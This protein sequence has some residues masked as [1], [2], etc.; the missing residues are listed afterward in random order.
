MSE[1]AVRAVALTY[2]LVFKEVE[3]LRA[4]AQPVIASFLALALCLLT[5][6]G[7]VLAVES[8]GAINV[9]VY[10]Q[11]ISRDD[12]ASLTRAV[13]L[14]RPRQI[15]KDPASMPSLAPLVYYAGHGIIWESNTVDQDLGAWSRVAPREQPAEDA[16]VAAVALAAM[17]VGKPGKPW[18]E[19]YKRTPRDD[20]SQLALGEAIAEA[21]KAASDQSAAYASAQMTWIKSQVLTGTPRPS[22]YAMLKSRGLVAYNPAFEE[23][24]AVGNS[25][26]LPSDDPSQGYWP[27]QNES[28][29]KLTGLCAS[30]H[31][32]QGMTPNPDAFVQIA[33]AFGLGCGATL[34]IT[35]K[36]DTNDRVK[37]LSSEEQTS[38]V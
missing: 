10:G 13:L 1:G 9:A 35:I 21:I 4:R 6:G 7:S 27:Y 19:L 28:P 26:C 34:L 25:A 2:K 20:A 17:D 37:G 38:C 24:R 15:R 8:F 5:S 32:E 16:F 31:G 22:V 29:P 11:P 3:V 36:F 18:S 12:I 23:Q 33:G 14:S 30:M